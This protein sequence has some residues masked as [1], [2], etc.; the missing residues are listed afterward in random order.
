MVGEDLEAAEIDDVGRAEDGQVEL[1]V[2]LVVPGHV[3]RVLAQPQLVVVG[4]IGALVVGV[5]RGLPAPV[6][7]GV[8]VGVRPR[9]VDDLG[10]GIE[11]DGVGRARKPGRIDRDRDGRTGGRPAEGVGRIGRDPA[12]TR[13]LVDRRVDRV[14]RGQAEDVAVGRRAE[15]DRAVVC[16]PCGQ[17][18]RLEGEGEA[19][20]GRRLGQHEEGVGAGGVGEDPQVD[21]CEDL[22]DVGP[23]AVEDRGLL[24]PGLVAGPAASVL[25]G[26]EREPM[27]VEDEREGSLLGGRRGDGHGHRGPIRHGDPSFLGQGSE[28][29]LDRLPALGAGRAVVDRIWEELGP[30]VTPTEIERPAGR[31]SPADELGLERLGGRGRL[32]RLHEWWRRRI[33]GRRRDDED[34]LPDQ[35]RREHHSEAS[36]GPSERR[37]GQPP[38]G[39]GG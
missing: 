28:A 16:E 27:V 38:K 13:R 25:D 22:D 33:L 34:R 14:G 9:V 31:G 24:A 29:G 18:G 30:E 15:H 36:P 11:V 10:R 39:A 7:V 26:A 5:V 37:H 17:A 3:G 8:A 32:G 4:G 23:R 19:W 2:G 35:K 6:D 21:P 20:L 12:R 1:E